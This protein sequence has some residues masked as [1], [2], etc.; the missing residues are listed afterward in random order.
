LQ[1]KVSWAHLEAGS[2]FINILKVAG[3]PK[4]PSCNFWGKT[5]D[6]EEK[7]LKSG[8]F[9][10]SAYAFDGLRCNLFQRATITILL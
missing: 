1:Q 4:L 5:R 9:T 6:F 3:N 10:F 8:N 2:V 7:S